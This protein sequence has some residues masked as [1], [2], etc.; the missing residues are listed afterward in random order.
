MKEKRVGRRC[1]ITA[2]FVMLA[3]TGHATDRTATVSTD[4]RYVIETSPLTYKAITD[5]Y[6]RVGDDSSNQRYTFVIPFQLPDINGEVV[7]N[8]TLSLYAPSKTSF[9][10]ATNIY[11]DVLGGRVNASSAVAD[12]DVSGTTAVLLDDAQIINKNVTAPFSQ[13][14]VLNAAFFQSIYDSDASA[15]GKYVFITLRADGIDPA[16]G[17]SYVTYS[18]A[19]DGSHPPA[20]MIQTAPMQLAANELA[21]DCNSL[22]NG[23]GTN[24]A[25]AY[26]TISAAIASTSFSSSG[27]NVIVIRGG[28]YR[29]QLNISKS[30]TS[31]TPLVLMAASPNDHVIISGMKTLDSWTAQGGGVYKNTQMGTNYVSVLY[32]DNIKLGNSSMP[33]SGWWQDTSCSIASNATTGLA[34][35]T[36]YDT[37]HLIGLTNSLTGASIYAWNLK[38]NLF[39]EVPIVSINTSTGQ[40]RFDLPGSAYLGWSTLTYGI[41]Y[42]LRNQKSLMN[43]NGEWTV[44]NESGTN[45]V[46]LKYASTPS[47]IE[48]P[49]LQNKLVT[50]QNSRSYIQLIGLDLC[51]A[52]WGWNTTKS[53]YVEDNAHNIYISGGNSIGIYDCIVRQAENTGIYITG[54]KNC[55]VANCLIRKNV[56]GMCLSNSTNITVRCNDA[57]CNLEDTLRMYNLDNGCNIISNYLHH[58]I[59]RGH[60]DAAQCCGVSTST[61]SRNHTFR[62]NVFYGSSQTMMTGEMTNSVWQNNI[63]Y[64]AAG[65]LLKLDHSSSGYHK[66]LNN[67]VAIGGL[68]AMTLTW[69][70]Y[71]IRSNVFCSANSGVL[72]ST[73]ATTNYT[74][75]Y[76]WF[77]PAPRITSP[78]ILAATNP[79]LNKV[80][81]CKTLAEFQALMP[82]QDLNST[83]GDPGFINAPVA[84]ACVDKQ[85]IEDCTTTHLYLEDSQY[86]FVGDYLE[87]GFD[88]VVRTV[89]AKGTDN[90][91]TISPALSGAPARDMVLMIWGTSSDFIPDLR[92]GNTPRGS[93]VEIGNYMN[94]DFDNDG[95]RDIP[96]I[97]SYL[98]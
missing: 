57:G 2:L 87:Y 23:P 56:M 15:A 55:E 45:A 50:I 63:F 81:F 22:I 51:G 75:D 58:S 6:G 90:D 92:A 46:Y 64:G 40:L 37:D 94:G 86:V 93:D 39:E 91:I 89:T 30:G 67:T 28:T 11:V 76:N 4:D 49:F 95:T 73:A 65:N 29:E 41:A 1:V 38:Q 88:G 20:L 17:N 32:A 43:A 83:V 8:V 12:A 34:E 98:Q 33:D 69:R 24:W 71:D 18:S 27:R 5:T 66:I 60:A 97:P 47:G 3:G 26:Q 72:Y 36:L 25:T 21:V 62:G 59:E 78:N 44:V 13:A 70:D 10:S 31:T 19:N 16:G 54:S 61:M 77:Y 53:I 74:G 35:V 14:L 42:S 96:V 68:A 84:T 85:R 9:S 79:A 80:T 52:A 48:S 82:G 7:T